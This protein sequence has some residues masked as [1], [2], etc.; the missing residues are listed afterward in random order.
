MI[1]GIEKAYERVY[2]AGLYEA[3]ARTISADRQ[4][5]RAVYLRSLPS[6][7]LGVLT[8]SALFAANTASAHLS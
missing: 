4:R 6:P 3:M 7:V 5:Y 8:S 2:H 1:S